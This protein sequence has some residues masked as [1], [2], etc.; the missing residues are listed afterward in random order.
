VAR[1]QGMRRVLSH[2]DIIGRGVLCFSSLRR[3]RTMTDVI[4]LGKSERL[5]RIERGL[6]G[7]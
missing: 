6:G 7:S 1:D 3:L 5:R 4:G 2:D